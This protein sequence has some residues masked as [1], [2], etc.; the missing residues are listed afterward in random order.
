MWWRDNPW[1]ASPWPW[2]DP[3]SGDW[4]PDPLAPARGCLLGVLIMLAVLGLI[5]WF[6]WEVLS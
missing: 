6:L 1:G 2:N 5:G 3:T 4:E